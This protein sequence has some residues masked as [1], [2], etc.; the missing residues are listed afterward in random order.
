MSNIH[1]DVTTKQMTPRRFGT[2]AVHVGQASDPITGAVVPPISLSTTFKHHAPGHLLGPGFVYSRDGNPTRNGFESAVAALEGGKHGVAFASGSAAIAMVIMT[3][4]KGSHII[5]VSD[6]YGGTFETLTKI[7][8][9]MGYSASFVDLAA[10]PAKI[11]AA[12]TP[13][14]K[15][16]WLESPTNP[17]MKLV[18]IAAVAASAKRANPDVLVGVDNTFLSPYF[19]RPLSLGADV[20]VH[21]ATKYLNGHSDVCMG[22][23]ITSREDVFDSLKKLQIA[24]GAVP[25]PM[26]CYLA[27]RGLKTLHL[28]MH[29]HESNAMALAHALEA[30]P[31]VES[32]I[33]PGLASHP[34]HELAK[35][36]M[37]G[38]GGMIAFRIKGD[39][40]TA[41]AFFQ[42]LKTVT[43]AESLGGVESLAELPATMTHGN[44]PA[45]ERVKLGITD[46]LI[47]VSVGVED[48]EDIIADVIQ[49][50]EKA[51]AGQ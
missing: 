34:Q 7:A 21:S 5:S 19:Q 37:S 33:Y 27:H 38:F 18:D 9:N 15:L 47:R 10:D 1:H 22:I 50:L 26:D 35:R 46:N 43:L 23:A 14:T 39:L 42:H 28:R 25:S 17:T 24:L 48:A 20:V 12:M 36:Q 11:T 44:L 8:P 40:S 6:V 29:A 13:A 30:S 31:L 32:V 3:L 41:T 4:P 16:I 49:A 45:E 51:G 2:A